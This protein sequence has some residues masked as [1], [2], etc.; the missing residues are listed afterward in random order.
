MDLFYLLCGYGK[1]YDQTLDLS[2][3]SIHEN[4]DSEGVLHVAQ[5]S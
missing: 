2:V 5:Q 1:R 3:F 4:G